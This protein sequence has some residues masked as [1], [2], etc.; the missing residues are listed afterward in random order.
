MREALLRLLYSTF[1]HCCEKWV[2]AVGDDC[3]CQVQL[4]ISTRR[5][6]LQM[7]SGLF[8]APESR[9]WLLSSH[10]LRLC[11]VYAWFWATAWVNLQFA[12]TSS[13]TKLLSRILN[14]K[15][16][17]A[18]AAAS[19]RQKLKQKYRTS[20]GFFNS[21]IQ[22]LCVS[23]RRGRLCEMFVDVHFLWK[24]SKWV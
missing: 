18:A 3:E 16:A 13:K 14:Q 23:R 5:C 9:D 22:H 24:S 17:A 19:P 2:K 11:L 1:A 8:V 4:L 15:D 6:L 10:S 12:V 20:L 7:R 21:L